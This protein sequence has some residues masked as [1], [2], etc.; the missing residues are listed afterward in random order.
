M[1][2]G[3]LTEVVAAAA[4]DGDLTDER[5]RQLWAGAGLVSDD[6]DYL[7]FEDAFLSQL[8]DPDK[9]SLA[10]RPGGWV[11]NASASVVKAALTTALLAVG[12]ISIGAAG[13]PLILIPA[14]L[15]ML[16]DIDRVRLTAGENYLLATLAL[17]DDAKNCT[18][19]ELYARISDDLKEQISELGFRDFLDKCI[20]AGVADAHQDPTGAASFVLRDPRQAD[21]RVSFI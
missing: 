1:T 10:F 9:E 15:P 3:D 7:S 17:T 6:A 20:K 18:A 12:L 21:F 5:L 13:I 4:Q 8:H 14:V 11:V 19:D 16:I 2:A